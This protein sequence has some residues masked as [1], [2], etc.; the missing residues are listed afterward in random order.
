VTLQAPQEFRISPRA[1]L[2]TAGRQRIGLPEQ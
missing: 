1:P 2:I